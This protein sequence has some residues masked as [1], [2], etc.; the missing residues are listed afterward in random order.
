MASDERSEDLLD[1]WAICRRV[2]RYPFQGVDSTYPHVDVVAANLVD[3]ASESFCDLAFTVD[4]YLPPCGDG[5]GDDQETGNGLQ[6][7]GACVVLKLR[8]DLLQLDTGFCIRY[9]LQVCIR[10]ARI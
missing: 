7:G 2:F 4:L 3:R 8:L 10:Q 9:R 1:L 6:D 5:A